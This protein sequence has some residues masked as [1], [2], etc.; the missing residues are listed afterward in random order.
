MRFS[1]VGHFH[2]SYEG[3]QLHAVTEIT[4]SLIFIFVPA[5]KHIL[6]FIDSHIFCSVSEQ[7]QLHLPKRRELEQLLFLRGTVRTN[8]VFKPV[9][10]QRDF[11]YQNLAIDTNE[12]D[13]SNSL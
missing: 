13:K 7:L 10:I 11:M 1:Y 8:R 3:V 12:S 4:V 9:D 6:Y 2:S 5:I